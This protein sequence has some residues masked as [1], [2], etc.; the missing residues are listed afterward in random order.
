MSPSSPREK[1]SRVLFGEV[2]DEGGAGVGFATI[3]VEFAADTQGEVTRLRANDA[4]QFT[5]DPV[6]SRFAALV[7]EAP[8]FLS[9]RVEASTLPAQAEAFWSQHLVRAGDALRIRVVVDDSKSAPIAGA[10]VFGVD[11]TP[12]GTTGDDGVAVVTVS[13]LPDLAPEDDD[14]FVG[15]GQHGMVRVETWPKSGELVVR[16]PP[17]A[18]VQGVVVDERG[19]GIA[20][21]SL[22]VV[23]VNEGD[24]ERERILLLQRRLRREHTVDVKDD[25]TFDGEVAAADLEVTARAPG[26]RP[27]DPVELTARP[28]VSSSL[29]FELADSPRVSGVVVDAVT[30]VGLAGALLLLDD[31]RA[32]AGSKSDSEGRF[33]LDTF[34]ERATSLTV[35]MPG[36][37]DHTLGGLDGGLRQ[38]N[39]GP[40][41]IEMTPGKGREVVGIGIVSDPQPGG[42]RV[43]RVEP[44][45][46]AARA[47][48]LADDFIFEVDGSRLTD[49]TSANLARVRGQRGTRVRLAL[50][51]GGDVVFLDVERGVVPVAGQR[52]RRH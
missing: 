26:K 29:R 42:L 2:V 7:F 21:A 11:R 12:L 52:P 6:P 38:P 4:G 1:R 18:V 13:T 35:L 27:S 23:V 41:R 37:R 17:A 3:V 34:A 8:G 5:L 22:D 47:G 51:R 33:V 9:A 16:L 30:G 10:A 32:A 31:T 48:I 19:V 50:R 20:G 36:Y 43:A 46:P 24:W 44:N 45:T 14:L 40:L 39:D 28:G 25:G 15:H 49:D